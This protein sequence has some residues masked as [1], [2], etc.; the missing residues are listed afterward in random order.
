ML[1]GAVHKTL[2]K[3]CYIVSIISLLHLTQ[4][5]HHAIGLYVFYLKFKQK[6]VIFLENNV[7]ERNERL[8]TMC[9]TTTQ[10]STVVLKMKSGTN[11]HQGFLSLNKEKKKLWVD[12]YFGM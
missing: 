11:L 1:L 10:A 3:H 4:F 5:E 7:H 6:E 9:L 2:A 8:H 12:S